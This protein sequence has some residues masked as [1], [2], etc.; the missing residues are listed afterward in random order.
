MPI[1]G[2]AATDL[3]GTMDR[4]GRNYLAKLNAA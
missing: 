2:A 1:T 4:A 3:L